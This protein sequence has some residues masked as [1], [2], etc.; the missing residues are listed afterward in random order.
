MQFADLKT[1]DKV[2]VLYP[3]NTLET[4]RI[5]KISSHNGMICMT[6]EGTNLSVKAIPSQ[7]IYQDKDADVVLFT[8]KHKLRG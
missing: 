4:E 2:W 1:N 7:S 5:D 8:E 6:F 3:D